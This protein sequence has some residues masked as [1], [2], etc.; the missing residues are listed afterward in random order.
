MGRIAKGA[1]ALRMGAVELLSPT[2]CVGCDLP[3][4]LLCP[5]CRAAVLRIDQRRACPRCGAPFGAL[6]CTECTD[7]LAPQE[8]GEAALLAR[9]AL[10]VRAAPSGTAPAGLPARGARGVLPH[11][12]ELDGACCFGVHAWPLDAAVRAYKDGGERRMAELLGAM[13]ASAA[14]AAHAFDAARATCVCFVPATPAA[15]ARRG[16]DHMEPLARSVAR[17][18][19]LPLVDALARP[20]AEDQRG[21]TRDGRL[22]GGRGGFVAVARMDG[23]RA[24][25][26]DDVLTTGATLSGAAR[27]LR[28]AGA[29]RVWAATVTR[30]WNG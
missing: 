10:L 3:G 12:R 14:S 4:G 19:G 8:D 29:E 13:V 1:A 20:Y 25:L 6:V 27:E 22:T 16:F 9:H 23:Q 15:F 7:S 30:A 17:R 11:M 18:L 2:R 5:S 26:L 28:A 24:I 21:L